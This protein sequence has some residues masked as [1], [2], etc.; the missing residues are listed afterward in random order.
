MFVNNDGFED[1]E[2][3]S[4]YC[5][6]CGWDFPSNK[7]E[8]HHLHHRSLWREKPED[9]L[10]VCAKCHSRLDDIRAEEGKNDQMKPTMMPESL[11]GLGQST[12]RIGWYATIQM[13]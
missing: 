10:L 7:L 3:L 9:V 1:Y 8:L 5:E 12:E 13:F 2:V 4:N 11:G 6:N